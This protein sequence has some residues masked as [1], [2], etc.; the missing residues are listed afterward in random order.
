MATAKQFVD[1]NFTGSVALTGF[2]YTPPKKPTA[3]PPP[4]QKEWAAIKTAVGKLV[5]GAILKG[6]K[7]TL[8]EMLDALVLDGATWQELATAL[9]KADGKA[10]TTL[11]AKLK[12]Q[13]SDIAKQTEQLLPVIAKQIALNEQQS[14]A[15]P[16][17][18]DATIQPGSAA[19]YNKPLGALRDDI[20]ALNAKIGISILG[21]D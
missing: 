2:T 7:P 21:L 19:T 16:F 8:K 9:P 4:Y 15:G 5:P 12:S 17:N 6:Q 14:K 3:S 18:T 20:H 1:Q 10:K 13:A 11:T